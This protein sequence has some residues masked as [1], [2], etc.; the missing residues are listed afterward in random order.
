MTGPACTV[1]EGHVAQ[2]LGPNEWQ[3]SL[4]TAATA[5]AL[6][7]RFGVDAQKARLAG[8]L[9][10]YAR[11]VPRAELPAVAAELGIEYGDVERTFPYLL[12]AAVGARLASK[13][14]NLTDDEVL[15]AVENHTVGRPH[16]TDLEK[17]IYL[18]DMIEPERTFEGVDEIRKAAAGDLDA[19]FRL[20]YALSLHHL[21]SAGKLIHPRT[22][23]VWNWLH[24]RREQ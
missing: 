16:M 7:E 21:I 14:L 15:R 8:L 11:S 2:R 1:D 12:H 6:A 9:H 22:V 13:E 17:I 3:H 19:A 4:R 5:A 18:A 23:E 20:G 24:A 10:D